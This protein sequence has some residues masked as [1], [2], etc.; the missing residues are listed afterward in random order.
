MYTGTNVIIIHKMYVN[1]TRTFTIL[2]PAKP[3]DIY[4]K[5]CGYMAILAENYTNIKRSSKIIAILESLFLTC[6]RQVKG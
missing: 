6:Y 4:V 3:E 5:K 1:N 2:F